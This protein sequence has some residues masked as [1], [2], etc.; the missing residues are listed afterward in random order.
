M[1]LVKWAFL[2]LS[3]PALAGPSL[4]LSGRV[5]PS[6]DFSFELIG[7]GFAMRNSGNTVALFQVTGRGS[8]QNAWLQQQQLMALRTDMVEQNGHLEIRILAP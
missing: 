8:H 3:A 6:I 7:N 5:P 4:P 2:L 1:K